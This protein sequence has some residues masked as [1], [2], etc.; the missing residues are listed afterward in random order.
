MRRIYGVLV[1]GAVVLLLGNGAANAEYVRYR[2]VEQNPI[3][4]AAGKVLRAFQVPEGMEGLD[5]VPSGT[6]SQADVTHRL[7]STTSYEYGDIWVEPGDVFWIEIGVN[8][9]NLRFAVGEP[10][11]V[12]LIPPYSGFSIN[13]R[14]SLDI[15][16][17]NGLVQIIGDGPGSSSDIHFRGESNEVIHLTV[18]AGIG[19]VE[20]SNGRNYPEDERPDEKFNG[21][22]VS[23]DGLFLIDDKDPILLDDYPPPNGRGSVIRIVNSVIRSSNPG[24]IRD[25]YYNPAQG[26]SLTLPTEFEAINSH[27]DHFTYLKSNMGRE[28]LAAMPHQSR[29]VFRDCSFSDI[30]MEYMGYSLRRPRDD[31][32]NRGMLDGQDVAPFV[33]VQVTRPILG[34]THVVD[35]EFNGPPIAVADVTGNGYVELED[36]RVL[37]QWHGTPNNEIP[38]ARILDLDANGTAAD[39]GDMLMFALEFADLPMNASISELLAS[40]QMPLLAEVLYR[41]YRPVA[42]A[43][44]SDSV[45]GPAITAWL[46]RTAVV[47]IENAGPSEFSLGQNYP[48]PFNSG[49]VIRFQI[50]EEVDVELAVYNINGQV[51]ARLVDEIL[52]AGAYIQKWDGLDNGKTAASGTYFYRIRAGEYAEARRMML[53]R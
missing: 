35:V 5:V 27:F 23:A 38:F 4:L 36:F 6:W 19:S 43:L 29:I 34:G 30:F 52:P 21:A 8:I 9:D 48:N 44:M 1:A 33:T 10:M 7:G 42:D 12:I 2:L 41:E 46:E 32:D 16:P 51:V 14:G 45:F 53:L 17:H 11:G 22:T 15:P 37:A 26:V 50:P 13:P 20:I 3:R 18:I 31:P 40:E 25:D 47:A 28:E 24:N 39:D 49:T